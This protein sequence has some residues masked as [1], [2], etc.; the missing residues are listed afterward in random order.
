MLFCPSTSLFALFGMGVKTCA[1]MRFTTVDVSAAVD[2]NFRQLALEDAR[3]HI[4]CLCRAATSRSLLLSKSVTQYSIV[5][6]DHLKKIRVV[7]Y[8]GRMATLSC[9]G[10]SRGS[11]DGPPVLRHKAGQAVDRGVHTSKC[12][13]RSERGEN[14]AERDVNHAGHVNVDLEVCGKSLSTGL[15]GRQASMGT[16]MVDASE[17]QLL[18]GTVSSFREDSGRFDRPKVKA[19]Q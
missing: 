12:R 9:Q 15:A 4:F 10:D 5:S 3:R 11:I 19:Q 1:D 14:L 16:L 13:D 18:H 7:R 8:W 2:L 6:D 17:S